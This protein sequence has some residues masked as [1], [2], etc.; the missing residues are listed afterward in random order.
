M[1]DDLLRRLQEMLSAKPDASRVAT[2]SPRNQPTIGP[3]R[4][5]LPSAPERRPFRAADAARLAAEF[6]PAGDVLQLG[7]GVGSLLQ[8]DYAAAMSSLLG[9]MVPNAIGST[10][11]RVKPFLG[12]VQHGPPLPPP[13]GTGYGRV[14]DNLMGMGRSPQPFD[15]SRYPYELDVRLTS[16]SAFEEG[17]DLVSDDAVRGM[18]YSHALERARRNWPGEKVEPMNIRRLLE[19]K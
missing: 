2:A 10:A 11:R 14:P 19:G 9:A 4:Q 17:V 6:S 7:E 15:K 16:P 1:N 12:P 13:K 5:G 18:N 3:A 8:G